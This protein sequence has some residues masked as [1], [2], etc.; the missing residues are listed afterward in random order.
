MTTTAYTVRL[1]A[2]N[3]EILAEVFAGNGDLPRVESVDGSRVRVHLTEAH[4]NYLRSLDPDSQ[5]WAVV[6]EDGT[7]VMYA[8]GDAHLLTA[9]A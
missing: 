2:T 3:A 7:T 6:D 1:S 4:V 9:I 5:D 8:A